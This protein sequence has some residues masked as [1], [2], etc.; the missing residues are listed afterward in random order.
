MSVVSRSAGQK[1][2]DCYFY[3]IFMDKKDKVGVPTSQ[4]LIE[5]SFINSD[6]KFAEVTYMSFWLADCLSV[7]GLLRGESFADCNQEAIHSRSM[8]GES[9]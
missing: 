1:V 7:V 4:Q 9:T 2:Q 8:K 5:W 3:Q 6:L